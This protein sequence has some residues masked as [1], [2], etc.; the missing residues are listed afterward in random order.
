MATSQK[1]FTV[2]DASE[3]EVAPRGRKVETDP[4]LVKAFATLVEGKAVRLDSFG[5][6]DKADRAKV[7]QKIRKNWN[8]A[9]NGQDRCSINYGTTGVPTVSIARPKAAAE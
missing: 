2:I 7:G 1:G 4:V 3:V 5:S 9:R 8:A 6:V